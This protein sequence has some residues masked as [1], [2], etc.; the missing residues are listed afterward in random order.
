[1]VRGLLVDPA[2][3]ALRYVIGEHLVQP[4]GF[5]KSLLGGGLHLPE[6]LTVSDNRVSRAHRV[7][8]AFQLEGLVVLLLRLG[9]LR[10]GGR[11]TASQRA[12][13]DRDERSESQ[14]TDP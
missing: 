2:E 1:M 5:V 6:I 8:A 13:A 4:P 11:M 3:F 9:R 12:A 14:P 10:G 7:G